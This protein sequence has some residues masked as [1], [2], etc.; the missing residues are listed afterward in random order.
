MAKYMPL[1]ALLLWAWS[2]H[3][4]D[5]IPISAVPKRVRDA[6]QYYSPGAQLIEQAG[7]IVVECAF[8]VELTFLGGRDKLYPY[9]VHSLI[10]YDS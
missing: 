10:S 1:A 4:S 9:L 8:L 2:V 5:K 3:A 6:I 7:G